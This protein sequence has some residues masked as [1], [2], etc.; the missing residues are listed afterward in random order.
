MRRFLT[1]LVP[2]GACLVVVAAVW[3]VRGGPRVSYATVAPI[4]AGKC[5]GCHAVGG[6][7]PFPLTR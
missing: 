4:F 3:G 7:A 1:A 2:L 6:I 5:A